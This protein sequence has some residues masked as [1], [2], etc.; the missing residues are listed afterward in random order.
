MRTQH[1]EYANHGYRALSLEEDWTE[2]WDWDLLELLWM[3]G[4]K[5]FLIPVTAR[6]ESKQVEWCHSIT[7]ESPPLSAGV[8]Q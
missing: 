7:T 5:A 1:M 6:G 3:I 4:S 8:Q 2:A